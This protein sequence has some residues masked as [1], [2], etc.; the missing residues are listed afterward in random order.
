[1]KAWLQ[2][3]DLSAVDLDLDVDG[4]IDALHGHDWASESARRAALERAG[5]EWCDP[6]LGLVRDDGDLLHI[7]PAGATATVH[8][9]SRDRFLGVLWQRN[10]LISTP[11]V[12]MPAIPELIRAFFAGDDAQLARRLA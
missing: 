6:G 2:S 1:M 10:R 4:A 9:R 12:P 3:A 5:D 8:H 7:C 11:S